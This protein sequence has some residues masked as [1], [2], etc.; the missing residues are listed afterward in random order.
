MAFIRFIIHLINYLKNCPFIFSV[1]NSSEP[2]EIHAVTEGKRHNLQRAEDY[3]RYL[4]R[5]S[6]P[7]DKPGHYRHSF[8]LYDLS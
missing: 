6:L 3:V 5:S 4:W 7:R 8:N 2:H 1:A